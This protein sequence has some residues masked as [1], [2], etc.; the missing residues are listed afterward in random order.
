MFWSGPCEG[1]WLAV[2][3]IYKTNTLLYHLCLTSFVFFPFCKNTSTLRQANSHF[4][5]QN[6][7]LRY[8]RRLFA[9]AFVFIFKLNLNTTWE[10]CRYLEKLTP[11]SSLKLHIRMR[12]DNMRRCDSAVLTR[13][14]NNFRK[15]EILHLKMKEKCVF[16]KFTF[17]NNVSRLC[18]GERYW[19][20]WL[21]KHSQIFRMDARYSTSDMKWEY[22]R[23][24]AWIPEKGPADRSLLLLL[25]FLC[26]AHVCLS[27]CD[28]GWVRWTRIKCSRW[29]HLVC[30]VRAAINLA[31]RRSLRAISHR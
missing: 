17:I 5:F 7:W 15:Y 29:T 20:E 11:R 30:R 25:L 4:L 22:S 8:L 24:N 16:F 10:K 3:V 26:W 12:G 2:A 21:L 27:V 9:G 19:A 1:L 14:A 23:S 13:T 18:S 31:A 28:S 6:V